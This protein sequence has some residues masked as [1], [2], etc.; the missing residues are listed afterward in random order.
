[1]GRDSQSQWGMQLYVKRTL[2]ALNPITGFKACTPWRRCESEIVSL[3]KQGM[4]S[5]LELNTEKKNQINETSSS[6]LGTK[7]KYT[8]TIKT[9]RNDALERYQILETISCP[10]IYKQLS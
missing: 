6:C 7:P 5:K 10:S 2:Q 4:V 9:S 8:H 1:M 3:Q